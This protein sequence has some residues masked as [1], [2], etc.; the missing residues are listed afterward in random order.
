MLSALSQIANHHVKSGVGQAKGNSMA[1][2]LGMASTRD[3]CRAPLMGL[4]VPPS[5]RTMTAGR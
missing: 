1:N 2:P 3:N 4:H 5:R